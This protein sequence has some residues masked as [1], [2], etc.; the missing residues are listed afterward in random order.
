[1][2]KGVGIID[3][4]NGLLI[5]ALAASFVVPVF[6]Q[7]EDKIKYQDSVLAL[8]KVA[9]AMEK[10]YLETGLYPAFQEFSQLVGTENPLVKGEYIDA[11]PGA[12]AWG[13]AYR[14]K[15]D[16][17]EYEIS[18]FAVPS[19]NEKLVSNHNDYKFSTG[20]KH[21]MKGQRS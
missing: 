15:S 14:G 8:R 17:K 1:M 6:K 11:V 13:R 9:A 2:K 10:H 16:G 18:G 19:K 3:I 7:K 20:A 5:L 12:D 4:L 21:G